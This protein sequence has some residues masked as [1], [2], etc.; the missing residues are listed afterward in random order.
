MLASVS[1]TE[2]WVP[3]NQNDCAFYFSEL[4]V[5][6]STWWFMRITKLT[7]SILQKPVHSDMI[8]EY[9]YDNC[10]INEEIWK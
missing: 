7:L 9:Y 10:F 1:L 6:L 8:K 5:V 2:L 4:T 3:S